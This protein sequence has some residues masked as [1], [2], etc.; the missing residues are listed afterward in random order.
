M[1]VTLSWLAILVI[2]AVG[3]VFSACDREQSEEFAL[4]EL[5]DPNNPDTHGDPYNLRVKMQTEGGVLLQFSHIPEVDGIAIYRSTTENSGFE[6]IGTVTVTKYIDEQV[7]SDVVYYYQLR[8]Y[9]AE[10][11]FPA[12]PTVS[13]YITPNDDAP[14]VLIPAG[15]FQMGTD[16][17]W[18]D[19][20]W[21]GSDA[22]PAHMVY[23]DAFY[24]DEHEVTNAQ[25][26]R[27]VESTGHDVPEKEEGLIHA[28]SDENFNGDDQPVVGITW[29][30]AVAYCKWTGKRLPTEAEWEKAARGGAEVA[31]RAENFADE[32]LD[33]AWGGGIQHVKNYNDGY[34]YTAPVGSFLPNDYGVYDMS[35]NVQEWC[36]DWYSESYYSNSPTYNPK[37]PD[38]GDS[39][40]YRGAAWSDYDIVLVNRYHGRSTYSSISLGL[41]CAKH[42]IGAATRSLQ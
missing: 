31:Y 6:K 40:V 5:F 42:A 29:E 16:A 13:I 22:T 33:E 21:R 7:Q 9:T 41:R 24:I 39:R 17:W 37:G 18:R 27:F 2:T 36:S 10:E 4:E 32:T 8:A 23:L 28:W 15:E 12:S 30:D 25:Y 38:S 19:Q 20:P 34:V 35:G 11:E 3:S 14:M 1:R 26:R